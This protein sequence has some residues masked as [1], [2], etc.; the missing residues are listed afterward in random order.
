MS[1]CDHVFGPWGFCWFCD[2]DMYDLYEPPFPWDDM[3]FSDSEPAGMAEGTG[4][5]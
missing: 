5:G 4:R 2:K 3:K 1:N